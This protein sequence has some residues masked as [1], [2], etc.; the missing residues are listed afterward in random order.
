MEL[1]II[2]NKS[3]S[4]FKEKIIDK[5]EPKS[6]NVVKYKGIDLQPNW[7]VPGSYF[8][9]SLWRYETFFAFQTILN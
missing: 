5:W 1:Y 2:S 4:R 3:I 7:E 6:T 9:Q 8:F